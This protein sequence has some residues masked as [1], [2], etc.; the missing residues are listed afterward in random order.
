M[1]E[2]WIINNLDVKHDHAA[3]A[4]QTLDV[5]TYLITR[6]GDR[7]TD[8]LRGQNVLNLFEYTPYQIWTHEDQGHFNDDTS[9]DACRKWASGRGWTEITQP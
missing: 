9:A 4:M 7:V 8:V 3:V 6:D 2:F 5:P 1:I